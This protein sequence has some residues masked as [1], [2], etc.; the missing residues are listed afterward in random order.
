MSTGKREDLPQQWKECTVF[1]VYIRY[2]N[3]VLI[4]G[5]IQPISQI[6]ET[7]CNKIWQY[8]EFSCVRD[9]VKRDDIQQNI[10]AGLVAPRN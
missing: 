4:I 3:T 8:L 5:Q 9:S 7:N 1:P 10:L 2:Y 6:A